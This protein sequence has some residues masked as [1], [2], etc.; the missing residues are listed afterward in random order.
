[1]A[2]QIPLRFVIR[3]DQTF[4]SFLPGPNAQAVSLLQRGDEPLTYLWGEPGCGKTHLLQAC[5]AQAVEQGR[6]CVYLPLNELLALPEA[7]LDGLESLELVCLDDL[8]QARD[9]APW[10]LAVFHLFNRVRDA[11]HRLLVSADCPPAALPFE[12]ADL[13]SRMG[14][15]LTLRLQALDDDQKQHAL[16]A[17]AHALGMELSAE[18]A[19]YL[20][21]RF[22]RD[23]SSLWRLLDQLDAASLSAQRRLT[24][25]F[26]RSFLIETKP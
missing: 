8:Q 1:M 22:P 23:L 5:C 17:R 11:G 14:W 20:L 18:V 6:S 9:N 4:D 24:I 3:E 25:P 19:R 2:S 26:V 16:T 21:S 12:L 13:Q 10:E 7:S 15:G